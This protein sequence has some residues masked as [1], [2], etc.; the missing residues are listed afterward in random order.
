M[1]YKNYEQF[2]NRWH[3][4]KHIRGRAEDVRPIGERRRTWEQVV[5]GVD[6]SGQ[7]TYG[8]KL[9]NTEVVT[10]RIDGMVELR[11]D[12]WATPSTAE[13]MTQWSPVPCFKAAK[14]LWVVLAGGVKVPIPESGPLIIG[15]T[16]QGWQAINAPKVMQK[17]VDRSKMK[18][19][20]ERI[21]AFRA[22]AKTFLKMSDGWVMN[23]TRA[24]YATQA[25]ENWYTADYQFGTPDNIS[26]VLKDIAPSKYEVAKYAREPEVLK[27]NYNYEAAMDMLASSDIETRLRALFTMLK[28]IVPVSKRV[29]KTEGR[30]MDWGEGNSH[31]FECKWYDY[32]YNFEQVDRRLTKIIKDN[33]DV[34]R[35]VERDPSTCVRSNVIV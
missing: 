4:T 19:A 8:A 24:A 30:T 33:E 17:A 9:Y 14:R 23:E 13:F 29:V 22:W 31:K 11:C 21:K 20:R 12:T 32:Q 26:R 25:E 7:E 10:Y 28:S 27:E 1:T 18:E 6:A 16:D 35:I 3:N 15:K 5:R 34:H 2:R